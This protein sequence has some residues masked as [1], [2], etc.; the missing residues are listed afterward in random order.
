MPDAEALEE[1]LDVARIRIFARRLLAMRTWE[2][3][4]LPMVSPQIALDILLYSAASLDAPRPPTQEFHRVT[5]HSKDR[6][7]EVM[8]DLMEQGLIRY[9]P[10]LRDARVRGVVATAAG[11]KLIDRYRVNLLGA[12]GSLKAPPGNAGPPGMSI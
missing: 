12:L 5:G 6:V 2:R 4:H 3:D 1:D 8:R 7:R 11:L 10:D 9:V